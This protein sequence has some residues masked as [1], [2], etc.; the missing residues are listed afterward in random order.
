MMRKRNACCS[1]AMLQPRRL[2]CRSLRSGYTSRNSQ[3]RCTHNPLK[4]ST[5]TG[6]DREIS[7]R[8][9]CNHDTEKSASL[10]RNR[11]SQLSCFHSIALVENSK[12]HSC[13]HSLTLVFSFPHIRVIIPQLS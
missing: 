9:C 1:C 10:T 13:Y 3:E 6:N 4:T 7:T 2:R 5:F 12:P 11:T 8:T